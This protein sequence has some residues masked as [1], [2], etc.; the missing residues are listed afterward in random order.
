M[1]SDDA[2]AKI[3]YWLGIEECV[4]HSRHPIG[5]CLF[6]DLTEIRTLLA[7]QSAKCDHAF[8]TND[9]LCRKCGKYFPETNEEPAHG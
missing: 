4:C 7:D 6:C 1:T 2:V 3:D 8:I 9:M 5:G